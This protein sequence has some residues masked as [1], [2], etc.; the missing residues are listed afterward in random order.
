L[1]NSENMIHVFPCGIKALFSILLNLRDLLVF[2][3]T[4]CI[5]VIQQRI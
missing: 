5:V 3:N 4:R 1:L 2:C